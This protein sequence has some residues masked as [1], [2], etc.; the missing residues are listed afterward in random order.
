[1][2]TIRDTTERPET[3]ES[4]SNIISSTRP[5]AVVAAAR[6]LQGAGPAGAWKPPA[7]YLEPNVSDKILRILLSNPEWA[8]GNRFS[9][10]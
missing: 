6:Y 2:I 10:S 9:R 7:E 4:G 1:V 5:G 3:I 8:A